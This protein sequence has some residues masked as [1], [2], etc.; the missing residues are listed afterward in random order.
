MEASQ[1]W[2]AGIER[3]QV[4]ERALSAAAVRLA[5]LTPVCVHRRP[6]PSRPAGLQL[7]SRWQLGCWPCP[8]RQAGPPLLRL[9]L[10]ARPAADGRCAASVSARVWAAG[11]ADKVRSPPWPVQSATRAAGQR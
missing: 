6:W 10:P 4:P 11:Q 7:S 1:A 5:A 9:L 3:V 2:H 8:G